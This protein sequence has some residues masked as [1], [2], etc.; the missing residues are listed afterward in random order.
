[1]QSDLTSPLEIIL[2]HARGQEHDRHTVQPRRDLDPAEVG[3]H[4][5]EQDDVE[6][7]AGS[8]LCP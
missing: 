3:K 8:K 1:M 5:V 6:A 7:P 4:H 2:G